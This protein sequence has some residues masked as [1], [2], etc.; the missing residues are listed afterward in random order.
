MSHQF[1]LI[2]LPRFFAKEIGLEHERL[3]DYLRTAIHI[4]DEWADEYG[5]NYWR[6]SSEI[7]MVKEHGDAFYA[8][9]EPEGTWHENPHKSFGEPPAD[10]RKEWIEESKAVLEKWPDYLAVEIDL[11]D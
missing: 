4:R 1:L 10:K 8:I 6:P 5:N 2:I 11:H 7:K 3:N 9:C